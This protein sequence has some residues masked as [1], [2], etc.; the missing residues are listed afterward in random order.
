MDW[1]CHPGL[2][3]ANPPYRLPILETSA[4]AMSG[5]TG[6][7]TNLKIYISLYHHECEYLYTYIHILHQSRCQKISY[8]IS[9]QYGMIR[10]PLLQNFELT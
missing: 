8:K 5:T 1:L 4:T 9:T 7:N 3:R 2:T 10:P 6:I